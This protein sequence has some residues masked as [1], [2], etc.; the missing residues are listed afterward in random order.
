MTELTPA[1]ETP[2]PRILRRQERTRQAILAA[3]TEC[4]NNKSVATVSVE[5]ITA[6]ADI[7]RG[8][9]YKLFPH[10]EEV[11]LQIARPMLKLYSTELARIECTGPREVFDRILGVYIRV[12]RE[13]PEAFSLASKE[14][15]NVF[16]L[17]EDTHRPAMH[18]MRR[19]FAYIERHGILRAERADFAV[20]L[21]ARSAVVV[22]RTF[23]HDPEWEALFR[24]SMSGFLLKDQFGRR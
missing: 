6:A 11:F 4:F 14:S 5:E 8:T 19:L 12:W 20:A 15:R 7:S 18:H 13:L 21:L 2:S 10:K 17:L 9:F 23:D 3:A 24:D 16:H 1:S 22:L